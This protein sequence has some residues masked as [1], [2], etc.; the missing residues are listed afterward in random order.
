MKINGPGLNLRL[1]R[2]YNSKASGA[3]AFG[4]NAALS[5]GR[6]VGLQVGASSVTFT[7]PSGFTAIFTGTGPTYTA[8]AG[9]NAALVRNG[10][11]TYALTYNKS[12]E[13]L[14]FTSGGFLTSD[15]DKNGNALSLLYN[16]DDTLASITDTAGRVT[17]FQYQNGVISQY[18]DPSG[19]HEVYSYAS[20][21]LSQTSDPNGGVTIYT[22]DSSNRLTRLQ[23]AGGS[24]LDFGYDTSNRVTSVKRYLVANSLSQGSVT[25][26]F[27]YPSATST[28][29][30]DAAS[31]TTTY[32]LDSL[33][34][35]TAVKNALGK[36][37][38]QTW[39]ANSDIATAV[40]A[41]GSTPS[42]GNATKFSYDSNNNLTAASIPT[43][44]GAA[45]Q[46]ANSTAPGAACSSTDTT[47]PYLVKCSE[48]AQGNQTSDT[49]D[50]AG[51]LTRTSDTTTSRPN[52]GVAK[53]FTYQG[54][55]GVNCGGKPGQECSSTTGNDNTTS[56]AYDANGDLT[57]VAP[58]TP[59]RGHDLRL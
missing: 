4:N 49:Y 59:G 48:D 45:A 54:D 24:Y 26:T 30:T 8:P 10:D 29:E 50:T 34:R 2:F 52:S 13:K 28:T 18:T 39:T 55:A 57:S 51:N 22:Y 36:T 23:S 27:A 44:A 37:R 20:G 38:S 56:Y 40:D 3:G 43:G 9:I 5:T 1:D 6:D 21:N 41:L 7:G 42:A 17:T 15:A 31:N 33:G 35:V 11:G 47:H 32:T 53:T 46:Y 25:T 19:R 16:A 58:P 12:G 14:T